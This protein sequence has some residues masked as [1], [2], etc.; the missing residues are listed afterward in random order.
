M[1]AAYLDRGLA[2][3]L[4][5]VFSAWLAQQEIPEA[6]DAEHAA[7]VIRADG[8][9]VLFAG[10]ASQHYVAAPVPLRECGA[11]LQRVLQPSVPALAHGWQWQ[12]STRSLV[13]ENAR[14]AHFTEREWALLS[15]LLLHVG[16]HVT[17]DALMRE[18]WHYEREVQSH[19]LETHIYR[20]RQKLEAL[21]PAPCSIAT[22]EHGY[23]LHV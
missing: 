10:R 6:T 23:V 14:V 13:H 7:V 9:G 15:Y 11:L 22:A 1:R 16:Q 5:R 19:T 17:Q 3:S 8:S 2:P 4:R 12:H 20:L 18:V 21:T